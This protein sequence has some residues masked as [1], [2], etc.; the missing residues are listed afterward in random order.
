MREDSPYQ[1]TLFETADDSPHWFYGT[2]NQYVYKFG[3][4][5]NVDNRMLSDR[6]FKGHALVFKILCYC[7]LPDDHCDRERRC[8][9]F[10]AKERLP[11]SEQYGRSEDTDSFAE[12]M[13]GSDR[14][15]QAVLAWVRQVK[16]TRA[17]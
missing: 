1:G 13:V 3:H 14:R 15:G 4:A 6:Q 8:E 10:F 9:V 12:Q 11:R 16:V 5:A 17:A 2:S 7:G